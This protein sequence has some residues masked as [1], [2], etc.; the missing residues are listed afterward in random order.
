M[1][2][3][4]VLAAVLSDPNKAL[5]NPTSVQDLH[6]EYN[7]IFKFGNRNA[8]SHLWSTF[9]FEREASMSAETLEMMFSGFCAVSG[10]PTRP[11]DYTRYRLTLPR[12]A[13]GVVSGCKRH[14]RGG[15]AA[16]THRI[17]YRR[18]RIGSADVAR[19]LC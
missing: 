14:T 3:L 17:F 8:A 11:S 16:E 5:W 13:G 10:S 19:A 15:T 12:V 9:L 18:L 7:N 4:P 6:R 1:S 2:V